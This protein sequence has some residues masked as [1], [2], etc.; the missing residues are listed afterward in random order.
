MD[1]YSILGILTLWILFSLITGMAGNGKKIGYWGV[2]WW[3]FL[4]SPV[5][6]FILGLVSQPIL[7]QQ[8]HKFKLY[9]ELG[10]KSEYKGEIKEAISYYMDGLY[11]LE[12]DYIGLKN[13]EWES[14]RLK[15]VET[16]KLKVEELQL[17]LTN[18]L[19]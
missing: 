17:K 14:G 1:E 19:K 7:T 5:V 18:M 9:I 15:L 10:K 12:N 3:S 11:H 16:Y 2:F 13:K 8:N 4:L 6:G